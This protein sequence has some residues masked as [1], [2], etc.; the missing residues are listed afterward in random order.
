MKTSGEEDYRIKSQ[1][2]RVKAYTRHLPTCKQK[3]NGCPC[4]K[5]LRITLR[6]KASVKRSLN[7]PSWAD[8]KRA[9]DKA[10]E[11]LNPQSQRLLQLEAEKLKRQTDRVLLADAVT[12]F[13]FS[14]K[15]AH[16]ET[17]T[18]DQYAVATHML[19]DWAQ[20]I[21]VTYLDE[22]KDTQLEIWYGQRN[23]PTEWGAL[24]PTTRSQRW[25]MLKTFLK[26]CHDRRVIEQNPIALIKKCKA[27]QSVQGPYSDEQFAKLLDAARTLPPPYN[28]PRRDKP[29]YNARLYAFILL[30]RYTGSDVCDGMEFRPARIR[31]QEI[32]QEMI[33]SYSYHRRKTK[34]SKWRKIPCV[35]E[36][37][38][39]V[40]EILRNVPIDSINTPEQPFKGNSVVLRS[41]TW[42]API[43][44]CL[45]QAGITDVS[46]GTG[47]D[48]VERFHSAN[49]KELR[50]TFAVGQ[51]RL[52]H[53]W[54]EVA[55]ML[56]HA[57]TDTIRIHYAPFVDELYTATVARQA[58]ARKANESK[59]RPVP[60]HG[61]KV[62]S[63]SRSSS[64]ARGPRRSEESAS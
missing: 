34:R 31:T 16:P 61:I 44:R 28:V 40:A 64:G 15:E 9:A 12:R 20:Q 60:P 46:C 58:R 37:P 27:D 3:F 48:N 39:W 41:D 25:G 55:G 24:A 43:R 10:L 13:L 36:L 35:M 62:V 22:I 50:H 26:F 17:R 63:P 18:P 54:E 45:K 4:P 59:P 19:K 5:Y 32:D 57:D 52:G 42:S 38:D 56:G 30:L 11:D 29:V 6:G 8:A 49:V 2:A 7:T 53:T 47:N 33:H 21:G 14:Q 1:Q 51:L 23:G